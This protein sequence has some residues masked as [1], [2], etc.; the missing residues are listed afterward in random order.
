MVPLCW[1]RPEEAQSNPLRGEPVRETA[2]LLRLPAD[3]SRAEVRGVIQTAYRFGGLADFA[4]RPTDGGGDWAARAEA[5]LLDPASYDAR[6]L[7][8]TPERPGWR[9]QTV[10]PRISTLDEPRPLRSTEDARAAD[11]DGA[12]E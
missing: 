7:A 8:D 10:P 5:L 11:P 3:G 6:L 2:L 9:L 12:V 4:Y 1:L